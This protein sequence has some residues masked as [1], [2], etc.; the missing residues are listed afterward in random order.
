[1]H[2]YESDGGA[3]LRR[4]SPCMAAHHFGIR[5]GEPRE[6]QQSAET[7]WAIM[8]LHSACDPTVCLDGL[9]T[10]ALFWQKLPMGWYHSKAAKSQSSPAPGIPQQPGE[11]MKT[12]A[13]CKW[14]TTKNCATEDAEAYS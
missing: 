5:D 3:E 6:L 9:D 10:R 4:S 11:P 8:L 1:M 2:A 14:K 12:H 7:I 13:C